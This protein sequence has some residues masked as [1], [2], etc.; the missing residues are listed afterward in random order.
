M[1]DKRKDKR[2]IKR[3]HITILC[4]ENQHKGISSNFSFSGLFIKTRKKFKP[5]S[6]VSMILEV[7]DS[8]KMSLRGTIARTKIGSKFDKFNDGIGIQLT[9]I[10]QAYKHH[11][12]TLIN[13]NIVSASA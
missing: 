10:P 8:Q 7:N 5:G 9:T 11:V 3:L 1:A 6:S 13:D 2:K 4:G 12:E